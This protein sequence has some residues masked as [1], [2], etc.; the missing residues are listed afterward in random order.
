[1]NREARTFFHR[2]TAFWRRQVANPRR[3]ALAAAA[4][5]ALIGLPG[6]VWLLSALPGEVSRWNALLLVLPGALVTCLIVYREA[7]LHALAAG[8]AGQSSEQPQQIGTLLS[9]RAE[10]ALQRSER[11]FHGVLDSVYMGMALLDLENGAFLQVN[12]PLTD[13][14]GYTEAELQRLHLQDILPPDDRGALLLLMQDILAGCRPHVA[15]EQRC[16]HRAGT[17]IWAKIGLSLVRDDEGQPLCFMFQADDCSQQRKMEEALWQQTLRAE[18]ILQTATDGF[19]IAT[20]E[21]QI[22]EANEAFSRITG[23]P[24]SALSHMSLADLD[25]G[26]PGYSLA[27]QISRVQEGPS[28]RFEARCRCQDGRIAHLNASLGQVDI[29]ENR[30]LFLSVQDMTEK[31]QAAA[32]LYESEQTAQGLI[33]HSHEGITIVDEEGRIVT[34]NPAAERITGS[35]AEE[36][37]GRYIWDVRLEQLP[38]AERTP[39][40]RQ[41]LKEFTFEMMRTGQVAIPPYP[42]YRPDGQVRIVSNSL[43]LI[44]SARGVLIGGIMRDMTEERLAEQRL[45]ES[46]QMLQIVLDTIPTRVFWKD[47]HL[48]FLGYNQ[49]FAQDAGLADPDDLIGKTDYDTVW[50]AQAEL[51]RANDQAVIASGQPRYHVE[52]LQTRPDGSTSWLVT[53]KIPLRQADGEIIGVL[54][55]YEDITARK[56]AQDQLMA[57]EARYHLL[58]EN[59]PVSLWE[60]DFSGVKNTIDRLRAEGVTDLQAYLTDHPEVVEDCIAQIQVLDV[61][62]TC[63]EEIEAERKEDLIGP[64]DALPSV[65]LFAAIQEEILALAEGR[66]HVSA[67]RPSLTLKGRETVIAVELSIA[68]G[69]EESWGRVLVSTV[70]ITSL[71]QAEAAEREQRAL[72]EALRETASII[73]SSLDPGEVLNRIL[74]TVGRVVPHDAANISLIQDGSVR[75]YSMHGDGPASQAALRSMRVPLETFNLREMYETGRPYLIS[76]TTQLGEHVWHGWGGT[77]WVRSYTAAPIKV[78]EQVIGFLNLDSATPGFFTEMHSERLQAF[79]DQV[80]IA[81]ENAQLYDEIRRHAAELEEH[82][83][84]RT[85][86]LERERAQL[87]AILDSMGEGMIYLEGGE[88]RYANQQLAEMIG[89]TLDEIMADL[90][91]VVRDIIPGD[92]ANQAMYRRMRTGSGAQRLQHNEMSLRRKDGS[93]FE[94]SLVTTLVGAPDQGDIKTVTLIRDISQERALQ[95]QKD[96]FIAYASHELRTPIANMKMRLYLLHRQPERSAEHLRVLNF[97]TDQMENLVLNLLDLSRFERGVIQLEREWADLRSLIEDVVSSQQPAAAEKTQSLT[98]HLPSEPLQAWID[99]GRII[100]VLTNLLNNAINYTNQGG[101]VEVTLALED[102]SAVIQVRDTGI[103]IPADALDKV[104]EPFFRISERAAPGSGLGL[105]ISRE[106]VTLHG[107]QIAV[108]SEIEKGSTF[109]VVLPLEAPESEQGEPPG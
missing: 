103:G 102:Q 77:G 34:W 63:V 40:Q 99:P 62:R 68:P 23:Y 27:A 20:E 71:K 80:A 16:L 74:E 26:D 32:A 95:K 66:S 59:V 53:S 30:F 106:I 6:A 60:E 105:S 107:G 108:N 31:Q 37:L 70:D 46:R 29:G 19:C 76:D 43:F 33:E 89:Y 58:F 5:V 84:A 57:S 51:Y 2:I 44:Q 67:E 25:A 38:E 18:L 54:G 8:Q 82:V 93:V 9:E 39:E 61:N 14:L 87:R 78:H 96:R 100:Q 98:Q 52:E 90:D 45:E 94:A 17:I 4:A 65:G 48:R 21:G 55:I 109:T 3:K 36:V 104:F 15:F 91:R 7:R 28:L 92:E 73:A 75:L 64:L 41:Q 56:A 83:A 35:R 10:D 81:L 22:L 24:L 42:I 88:A 11:L 69:Y 1:M 12:H 47:R 50:A 13:L 49:Q 86:E 79:A 97:V 85:A 101:Q 72:A